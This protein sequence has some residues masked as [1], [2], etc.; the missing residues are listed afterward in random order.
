MERL[1]NH[2]FTN[3]IYRTLVRYQIP[4]MAYFLSEGVPFCIIQVE[5]ATREGL[6]PSLPFFLDN[7]WNTDKP[8]TSRP[9]NYPCKIDSLLKERS[10]RS[11]AHQMVPLTRY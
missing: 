11:R 2:K 8:R 4:L 3:L 7:A 5:L 6:H 1:E 10:T 9:F